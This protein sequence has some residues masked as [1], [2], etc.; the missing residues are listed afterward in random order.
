MANASE[1]ILSLRPVSFRYEKEVDAARCLSFRLIAEEVAQVIEQG[2]RK[3]E[4][5]SLARETSSRDKARR[6]RRSRARINVA[7]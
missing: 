7:K 6:N 1:A 4:T 2:R 5:Y 3:R